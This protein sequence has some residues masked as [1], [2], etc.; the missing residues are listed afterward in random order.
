MTGT[1]DVLRHVKPSVRSAAA[2]TL[3]ARRAPVKINQNENPRD[4]PDALKRRVVAERQRSLARLRGIEDRVWVQVQG[5]ERVYAVADE[6]LE[7]E[8][9]EKTSSVHFLRFELDD[10]ARRRLKQGA[11]LAMGVD[12][13]AY[14]ASLD[15]VAEEL[16]AALVKDLD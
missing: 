11:R 8:N 14:Q 6:D 13:P 9:E 12:H 2:Y 4:L 3:A 5:C 15:P 1:G 7:R 10:E 16:R